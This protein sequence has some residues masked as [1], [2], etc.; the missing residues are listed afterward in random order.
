MKNKQKILITGSEGLIGKII[1]PALKKEGHNLILLDKKGKNP[2]DLLKDK[3]KPYFEGVETVIHLAIEG[4]LWDNKKKTLKNVEMLWNV[5]EACKKVNVKRI[6]NASS[7]NVYNYSGLYLEKKKIN[8]STPLCPHAKENWKERKQI[9]FYY[10]TSKI[11][12]ENL[13]KS[14]RNTFGIFALNLR[15][16]AVH[17]DNHPYPNEPDDNAIW[18]SHEDLIEIIKRAINF[19]GYAELVCVS[20][21]SEKFVDLDPLKKILGYEY[22]SNS[23]DLKK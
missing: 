13:V 20:N 22:K 11:L 17:P 8:S 6:V 14:Y 9:S 21:N 5:L 2:V 15:F 23:A 7:I 16:G 12:G 10:S 3:I 18:I 4:G 1:I 19:N